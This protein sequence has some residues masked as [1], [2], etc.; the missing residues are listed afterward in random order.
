MIVPFDR[1]E[2]LL[3]IYETGFGSRGLDA[4]ARAS[5]HYYNTDDELARFVDELTALLIDII[6]NYAGNY[7]NLILDPDLDTYYSMDALL[8]REALLCTARPRGREQAGGP[9]SWRRAD[10]ETL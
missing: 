10:L 1:L 3:T 7:S 6:L 4:V 2:E 5:V 8:L 9:T